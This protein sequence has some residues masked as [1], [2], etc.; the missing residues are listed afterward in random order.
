MFGTILK[1]TPGAKGLGWKKPL[2]SI[3][4][5]MEK[6]H[7]GINEGGGGGV[8]AEGCWKSKQPQPLHSGL[9]FLRQDSWERGRIVELFLLSQWEQPCPL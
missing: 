3:F 1:I 6:H 9:L 4:L 2:H 5:Q 7:N 8:V